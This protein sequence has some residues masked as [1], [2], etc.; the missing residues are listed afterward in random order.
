MKITIDD[1]EH[2]LIKI[3]RN[4]LENESVYKNVELV[5]AH[6]SL[7][8][9]VIQDDQDTYL[10]IE[11]KSLADLSASIKDGRYK[12]QSYRLHGLSDH[13]HNIVYLIEGNL[14]TYNSF[15]D[16]M[17]KNTL[18]SAMFSLNYHKGF[19]VM[20]SIHINET[21]H[22]ICNIANKLEKTDKNKRMGFYNLQIKN[23]DAN[24]DANENTNIDTPTS[25]NTYIGNKSYCDVIKKNK[26]D[27]ITPDN[28]GEIMLCQIPGISAT[29]AKT[30]MVEYH[31]INDLIEAINNDTTILENITNTNSKGQKR[32]INKTAICNIIRYLGKRDHT[33]V[34]A[35]EI[36][37]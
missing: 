26:K 24:V 15:R 1:R 21:A 36:S 22:M 31:T 14:I 13:N 19:S 9:I 4:Y 18:Y 33:E 2:E 12:E 25:M 27:N 16:K 7:G 17:D 11:R 37:R 5:V 8:D 6:L 34:I 3:C 23:I 30:I 29:T 10:I 32:K 20:R 35:Q 28:I